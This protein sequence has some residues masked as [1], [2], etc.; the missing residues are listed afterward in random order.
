MITSRNIYRG[1]ICSLCILL[2]SSLINAG[3]QVFRLNMHLTGKDSTSTANGDL[4]GLNLQTLFQGKS[5]C[6][7]YIGKIP[8]LLAAKGFPAASVDTVYFDSTSAYIGLFL[9][10]V[11]RS[12]TVNADSI[13]AKALEAAGWNSATYQ[14]KQ[15]DFADLKL[16]QQ[17]MLKYYENSGYP[18]ASVKLDNIQVDGDHLVADLRADKGPQYHI[19]SIRVYGKVK[20]KNLFLQKY[21]GITNGS[22][23]NADRL[24]KISKRLLELPYMLEEK[25]WDITMLGTGA[26][27]NLYLISKRSSQVNFL[28]GFLPANT[29]T[30]KSQLTA[31]VNLNLKN[32]L[33]AGESILLKWQQLQRK[34]PRLNVGYQHPYIFNSPFG[35]DFKFDLLKRDS[36]YLLI[37]GQLGLQYLLSA[38][39]SGKV[40]IQNQKSF[41][42]QGGIDTNIIKL[43]KKLPPN[44]DVSSTNIGVDYEWRNTNYLYNPRE[45]NEFKLTTSFGLKKISRNSDITNLK[46]PANPAFKFST[47][48]DS[49][50][51]QN[52]Q[53]R[54]QLNAAHYFPA[55]KRSVLKVG[56]NS[57]LFGSENIFRNELFQIGGYALLRGFDE[58]SIY[59]SGYAVFTAEY[60][61]LVGLNSFLFTFADFGLTKTR[62][63]DINFGNNFIGIGAGVNF[64]GKFGLLNFSYA[65]GKRGDVK[66][67]LRG[68]SKIHFG[69]I[70]YF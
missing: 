56:L 54:L 11:F 40:F 33:A 34:S 25:R 39:R 55:A 35:I 29:I 28:V 58:E 24:E 3:A 65:I 64:E 4:A 53:Y 14:N 67:D 61:Y 13:E 63:L 42:L 17:R 52:Y 57:G 9:G 5:Q 30:G 37:A 46:D 47:L 59:A 43:T 51:L 8:S 6:I 48:Y 70:N 20:I 68:A 15:F 2:L 44:I 7:E 38:N 27:L 18:F 31:D 32:S 36:S 41:L 45:G 62:F 66:F 16:Q 19:D 1:F 22:L 23:Y 50:K 10:P 60:R 21:L 49:L 26:I 12:V 69:Y